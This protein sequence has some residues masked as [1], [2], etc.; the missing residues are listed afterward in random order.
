ML[1]TPITATSPAACTCEMPASPQIDIKCVP[2]KPFVVAPH[3]K[4]VPATIQKSRDFVARPS[5][6][7]VLRSGFVPWLTSTGRTSEF[8]S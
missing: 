5:T 4:N 7:N 6:A 2:M 3:T 1:K 8:S